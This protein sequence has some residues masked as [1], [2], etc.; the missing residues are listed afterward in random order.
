[1]FQWLHLCTWKAQTDVP[2]IHTLHILLRT[3]TLPLPFKLHSSLE[4]AIFTGMPVVMTSV[5]YKRFGLIEW[6]GRGYYSTHK[7]GCIGDRPSL[8]LWNLFLWT[9]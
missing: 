3:G 5:I 7:V 8:Q 9:Q 1:M 4:A 6:A 2:S